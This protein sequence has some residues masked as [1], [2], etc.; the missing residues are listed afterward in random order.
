MRGTISL[1]IA[2]ALLLFGCSREEN[3]FPVPEIAYHLAVTDSIGT[4]IGEEEYM[5]GMASDPT[6]SPDG[7]ILVVDRLKH[8]VFV[9]SEEGEYLETIGREGE[10]PGEYR[11]PSSVDFYPDGSLLVGDNDGITLL[12]SSFNYVDQVMWDTFHPWVRKTLDD[13]GFIGNMN[14]FNPGEDGFT[15]DNILGRWEYGEQDVSVEYYS[16]SS[17]MDMSSPGTIDHTESRDNVLT[18]CASP[19]GR[20]F[21]SRSVLDDIVIHGCEPDGTEFLLIDEELPHRV[22]K[23]QEELDREMSTVTAAFSA[24]ARQAGRSVNEIEIILDPYRRTV[25]EMFVDGSNRLWVRLGIYPGIVFRVYDMEGNVL[26]HAM[27]DYNGDQLDLINWTV[28]GDRYGF[29]ALNTSMEYCQKVYMMD[30]V[31]VE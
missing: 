8:Y 10:G 9:Y 20:V 14:R 17:E 29:L 26:F 31:E 15:I 28:S 18:F 23:T 4:E 30:L 13:G 24:M 12:D 22:R 25:Q 21:Y 7:R 27:V 11:M 16:F 19:N 6:Y 3:Y 5:F 1:V 2:S